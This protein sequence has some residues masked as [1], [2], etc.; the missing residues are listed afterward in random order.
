MGRSLGGSTHRDGGTRD[1]AARA[2][3]RTRPR[4]CVGDAG[5]GLSVASGSASVEAW[6]KVTCGARLPVTPRRVRACCKSRRV[7]ADGCKR[8][9]VRPPDSSAPHLVSAGRGSLDLPGSAVRA[10]RRGTKEETPYVSTTSMVVSGRHR[11]RHRI[12]DVVRRP[13]R[14]HRARAR[15][16]LADRTQYPPHGDVRCEPFGYEVT[17]KDP[18]TGDDTTV[19]RTVEAGTF[20]GSAVR[21]PD[22]SPSRPST[23]KTVVVQPLCA[24]PARSFPR[25][26]S[27]RSPST[28]PTTS[29]EPSRPDK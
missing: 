21:G 23:S 3:C 5:S 10:R 28:M 29:I 7:P 8:R 16:P 12:A 14:P 18:E 4:A 17:V 26:R 19:T 11:R 22:S 6:R 25:S 24:P 9:T 20:N 15:C 2:R 1:R 27:R 13:V